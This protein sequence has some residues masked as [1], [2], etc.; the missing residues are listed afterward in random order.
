MADKPPL[1]VEARESEII[2][3]VG[4]FCAVYFRPAGQTQLILRGRT[5]TDDNELLD[6]VW[7]AANNKAREL[8]WID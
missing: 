8:G 6:Q 7:Q 3:T 5:A 1:Q 4:D 2:V